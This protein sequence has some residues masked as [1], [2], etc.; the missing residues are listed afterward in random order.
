MT[1]SVH[2]PAPVALLAHPRLRGRR[3]IEHGLTLDRGSLRIGRPVDYGDMVAAV[4]GSVGVL[5]DSGGLQKEAFLLGR[6]CTTMRPETEWVETLEGG[7]NV[8]VPDP[9]RLP[10]EAWASI[11]TRSA[12]AAG[13]GTPYGDG[14]ASQSVVEVLPSLFDPFWRMTRA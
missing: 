2:F 1:L 10:G 8:L 13:R 12:P 5:T 4:L 9:H 14:R 7:W 11:A 6:P 3:R